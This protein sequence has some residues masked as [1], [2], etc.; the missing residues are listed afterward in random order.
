MTAPVGAVPT[1]QS[2]VHNAPQ[3][4]TTDQ[5]VTTAPEATKEQS[6]CLSSIWNRV[7]LLFESIYNCVKCPFAAVWNWMCGSSSA[8]TE[9]AATA[10]KVNTVVTQPAAENKADESKAAESVQA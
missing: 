10:D 8:T 5:K 9:P 6:N 4:T 3:T 7:V 2:S 1:V